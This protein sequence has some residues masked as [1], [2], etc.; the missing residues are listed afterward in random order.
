V[1]A[2]KQKNSA[3]FPVGMENNRKMKLYVPGCKENNKQMKLTY[4]GI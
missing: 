4:K 1:Y 3:V 2:Q